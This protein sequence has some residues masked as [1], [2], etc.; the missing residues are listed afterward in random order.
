M[1]ATPP[2]RPCPICPVLGKEKWLKRFLN[3]DPPKELRDVAEL[4]RG[5]EKI[6]KQIDAVKVTTN[7]EFGRNVQE[8]MRLLKVAEWRLWLA[9]DIATT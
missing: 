3:L 4:L 6:R 2:K 8:A 9:L 1:R 7:D 5:F